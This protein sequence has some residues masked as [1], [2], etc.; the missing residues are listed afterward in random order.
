[1]KL[2]EF[3]FNIPNQPCRYFECFEAIYNPIFNG[4]KTEIAFK[5]EK[6]D[7]KRHL[8]EIYANPLDLIFN[9]TTCGL[10]AFNRG[11]V[12]SIKLTDSSDSNRQS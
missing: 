3:F 11:S 10:D 2:K 4:E 12:F 8:K 7:C 6:C 5:L 1:M 9:Q